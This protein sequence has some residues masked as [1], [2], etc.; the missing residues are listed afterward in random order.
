MF[1]YPKIRMAQ[2]TAAVKSNQQALLKIKKFML[3]LQKDND[4]EPVYG[5]HR[6]I[7]DAMNQIKPLVKEMKRQ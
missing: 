4:K 2:V 7:K 5:V 6:K 3:K 1:D